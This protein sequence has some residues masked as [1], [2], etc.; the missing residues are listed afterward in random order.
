MEIIQEAG[1]ETVVE[2]IV[3]GLK[4][5]KAKDIVTID[6]SKLHSAVC[7]YFIVCHGDSTTQVNAL[8]QSV[9]HFMEE[10]LNEKV[11]KKQGL[12][13]CQWVILDYANV[14][15]HIFL[16]ETR[17]YYN[18]EGLWADGRVARIKNDFI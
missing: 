9:E 16:R 1:I 7:K 15:V 2:N 17:E 4:D 13:N 3:E 8:A 10:N 6:I 18:L 5:R 11:W 12:E 14:V